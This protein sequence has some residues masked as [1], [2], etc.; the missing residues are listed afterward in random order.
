MEQALTGINVNKTCKDCSGF[1]KLVG[2]LC[3]SFQHEVSR[4]YPACSL[5]SPIERTMGSFRHVNISPPTQNSGL[6]TNGVHISKYQHYDCTPSPE[7]CTVSCERYWCCQTLV[8]HIN[9][10]DQVKNQ[11]S[12]T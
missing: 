12:K 6:S 2:G 10:I 7:V 11:A 4:D 1:S 9:L 8:D 3:P 5:F